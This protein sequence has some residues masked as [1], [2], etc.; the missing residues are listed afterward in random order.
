MSASISIIARLSTI[1][2]RGVAPPSVTRPADP[3]GARRCDVWPCHAAATAGDDPGMTASTIP[4]AV[5]VRPWRDDDDWWRVRRLLID[6]HRDSPPSWNWGIRR[7]DGG[8]FHNEDPHL[9]VA[10]TG[11]IGLWEAADGA[12][13]GAVH[14]E[15]ASGS[16]SFLELDPRYRH[17]Q[18]AML[19]WAERHAGGT[20]AGERRHDVQAWDYDLPRRRLLADNGYAMLEQGI[21]L[22]RLRPLPADLP[23]GGPIAPGYAMR[24]TSPD[25][26]DAARMAALLN[27]A[28]GRSIHTA[29]EYATFMS[30][31]PSFRHDLN[32]VAV[33]PDGTF[34]AHVGLTLDEHNRHAVIEPVCTHPDHVRRGLARALLF[35]GV[36]RV[37]ALGAAT[38]DVETGDA[39]AAN[40]FYR[41]LGFTE[42][43]RGHTWRRTIP[44]ATEDGDGDA[45]TGRQSPPG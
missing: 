32:L 29:R 20:T 26:G 16:E 5:T 19:D 36:A 7:W 9:A 22:R 6:A 18:P 24:E 25:N 35:E 28:F 38:V 37:A 44:A 10:I 42:E 12:L 40:A 43:Y 41:S 1:G 39:E 15:G 4:A 14:P 31:S 23:P 30:S 33:A 17:L 11:R 3:H 45:A 8:R 21:W 13:V 27:A 2:G 34:A